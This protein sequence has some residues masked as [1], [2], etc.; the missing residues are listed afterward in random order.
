MRGERPVSNQTA[1]DVQNSLTVSGR[2]EN[3]IETNLGR[4]PDETITRVTAF[5]HCT[6][7]HPDNLKPWHDYLKE[8][9][10]FKFYY[11]LHSEWTG[12]GITELRKNKDLHGS[13]FAFSVN[14][15]AKE[16][17]QTEAER[18]AKIDSIF[19]YKSKQWS[20]FS[21]LEDWQE[22][23]LKHPEWENQSISDLQRDFKS[24]GSSFTQALYTWT[25]K[26]SESKKDANLLFRKIITARKKNWRNHTTIED[27]LE[28][29]VNHPEWQGRTLSEMMNDKI[30]GAYTFQ[31]AFTKWVRK[32]TKDEEEVQFYYKQIFSPRFLTAEHWE[33][34]L[35]PSP[36][37]AWI[38]GV[39]SAGGEYTKKGLLLTS[40]NK[41]LIDKMK[42]LGQK[43][44]ELTGSE[45]QIKNANAISFYNTH[46]FEHLV[47]LRK[48]S[49]KKTIIEKHDWLYQNREYILQF[50]TGF[51]DLR[52]YS[53]TLDAS[54]KMITFRH[55]TL[56]GCQELTLMLEY[57][58]IVNT[59]IIKST[60]RMEGV[61][62]VGVYSSEDIQIF[63]QQVNSCIPSKQKRLEELRDLGVS[64][65]K[66]I[67]RKKI[68]INAYKKVIELHKTT[69]LGSTKLSKHPDLVTYN[70]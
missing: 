37:F 51:F 11:E 7:T 33:K 54:T 48:A 17:S 52:G 58:G 60:V 19:G 27:W 66:H 36:E 35:S 59:S 50:I 47:D 41:E 20:A 14:K 10:D 67:N 8:A 29:Y 28:E 16:T 70:L 13:G 43:V 40:R 2:L 53:T 42:K 15:W 25:K 65:N 21:T 4:Y 56:E 6:E 12:V 46:L 30:S 69:G 23:F 62:G 63:T 18:I 34:F 68:L 49:W 55:S 9:T 45:K 57:L 32:N 64:K 61:Q 26:V 5:I 44:F 39:L 38:L 24:G 3:F 22:E 1:K 31:R